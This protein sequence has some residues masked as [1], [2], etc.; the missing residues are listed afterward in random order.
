MAAPKWDIRTTLYTSRDLVKVGL[1]H[2][3]LLAV[4]G[5]SINISKV[6]QR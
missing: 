2:Y 4:S 5:I 1:V 6:Y 3:E